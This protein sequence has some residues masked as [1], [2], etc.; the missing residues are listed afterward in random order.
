MCIL[1]FGREGQSTY[2]AIRKVLPEL[3]IQICDQTIPSQ[4]ILDVITMDKNV[5]FY[6]GD[7]YLQQINESDM[8]VKTPGIPLRVLNHT[9]LQNKLVSQTELFLKLYSRQ[10]IGIT[11]TKGKS[12]TSSLLH[13][14]F[15]QAGKNVILVGN[16][17]VPPLDLI[18]EIQEDT[19]I[20]FEMSSHQLETCTVSPHV[21]VLLNIFQEHL[22]HYDSYRHYQYAKM[23]IAKWQGRGD[24]F[25]FNPLNDIIPGLV[26]EFSTS[27]KQW[28][29]GSQDGAGNKVFCRGDD[30]VIFLSLIHI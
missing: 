15:S 5:T 8:I 2:H 14:I 21:S 16:I 30:L 10:V 26:D 17:G 22:D 19:I 9:M 28:F 24:Y 4:L 7:Q 29:I 20:V 23:N 3:K 18:G 12:T 6:F 25:I 1:G 13:H 11:G 27:A